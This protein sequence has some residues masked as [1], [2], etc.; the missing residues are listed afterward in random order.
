MQAAGVGNLGKNSVN[1]VNVVE[2]KGF[3]EKKQGD[4][5]F[6]K[7]CMRQEGCGRSIEGN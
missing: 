3:Q 5:N 4:S 6:Y 1:V 7:F 2:E